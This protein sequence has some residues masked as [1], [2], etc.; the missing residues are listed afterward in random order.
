MAVC[1]LVALICVQNSRGERLNKCAPVGSIPNLDR[2]L[3]CGGMNSL[4]APLIRNTPYSERIPFV[5]TENRRIRIGSHRRCRVFRE[6][7]ACANNQRVLEVIDHVFAHTGLANIERHRIVGMKPF[8]ITEISSNRG[9]AIVLER[10]WS[11][12]IRWREST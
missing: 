9:R 3:C 4:I 11:K 2:E 1:I 8:D 10:V 5:K 12:S 6:D 7:C